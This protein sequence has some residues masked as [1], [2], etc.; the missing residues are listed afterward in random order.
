M[1]SQKIQFYRAPDGQRVTPIGKTCN[2]CCR[3]IRFQRRQH[4]IL[5]DHFVCGV[6]NLKT[7]GYHAACLVFPEMNHWQALDLSSSS[8]SDDQPKPDA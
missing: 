3:L 8:P 5:V 6:T 4:G 1:A 7:T 2:D